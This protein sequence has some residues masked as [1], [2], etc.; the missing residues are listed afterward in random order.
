MTTYALL[1]GAG[2]AAW[3]WHRVVP[4]LEAAGHRVVAVELPAADDGAGLAE[5]ADVAVAALAELPGPLVVVAQ[6]MGAFTAPLVAQRIAAT[7]LIVLVSP[8]V[9][10][11]GES[12]GQWW[13]ATGQD[14]AMVA[15]MQRIGLSRTSFDP[16]ADLF[17]DVP[18]DVR[19]TVFAAPEPAQS[20]TPFEQ[21]WPLSAW[22]EIPTRVIQGSDD[23]LF[24]LEFQRKV[25]RDRLG[26][27]LDVLP[28]GHL[29]ALS[30]PADLAEQLLSYP[31]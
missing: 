29:I 2:G 10:A 31:I 1:P 24:P 19:A 22:P 8:M 6:S 13:S 23:R 18:D 11:A 28:G 20:N 27:D 12:P 7:A 30:R 16:V 14:T 4:L 5:Y 3:Y 26:L 21:T 25:V 15:N 17:H 9:P